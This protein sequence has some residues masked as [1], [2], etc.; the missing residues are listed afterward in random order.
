MKEQ[1]TRREFG[2]FTMGASAAILCSSSLNIVESAIPRKI[3]RPD[4]SKLAV[5]LHIPKTGGTS[6]REHVLR[7][8]L[9]EQVSMPWKRQRIDTIKSD[10]S[11]YVQNYNFLYLRGHLEMNHKK[12]L[13]QYQ[14]HT[15]LITVL[16][17]PT[18][19]VP[20]AYRYQMANWA[21]EGDILYPL[22]QKNIDNYVDLVEVIQ[23]EAGNK[24]RYTT[25]HA[26]INDGMVRRI[27]GV[28]DT[29]DFGEI[30]PEILEMAKKNLRER[31]VLIGILE[32]FNTFLFMLAETYN[33][34][35]DIEV[36]KNTT[37]RRPLSDKEKEA[38]LSIN[39]YDAQLYEYGKKLSQDMFAEISDGK[40]E[41]YKDF[42]TPKCG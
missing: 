34:K 18:G 27:S 38:I 31:F 3:N 2:I 40:M 10:Y 6:L 37:K 20:S 28:G 13:E 39:Q 5:F 9:G 36:R 19:R 7:N 35:I 29:V 16:R 41:R 42:I 32:A 23:E 22:K 24:E 17:D 14:A 1:I 26:E 11:H 4:G 21:N 15:E 8:T 25:F 12:I 33:W 30:T